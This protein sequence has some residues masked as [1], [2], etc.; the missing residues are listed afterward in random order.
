MQFS[1]VC[2]GKYLNRMVINYGSDQATQK[3]ALF[4][5]VRGK[6]HK[7]PNIPKPASD[8]FSITFSSSC[9]LV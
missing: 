2:Q 5:H 4:S 8:I 9:V 1:S 6:Y 3:T 7:I